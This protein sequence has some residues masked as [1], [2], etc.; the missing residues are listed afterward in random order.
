MIL[1]KTS[2]KILSVVF[3]LTLGGFC[4]LSLLLPDRMLSERENRPL[5][6]LPELSVT[7]VFK[8]EYSQEMDQY[9]SDQFPGRD[10]FVGVKSLSERASGKRENN[11]I[12]FL[13]NGALA[14]RFLL[15]DLSLAEGNIE[16]VRRFSEMV[17]SPVTLALIP[18]VA[19]IYP[20][21]LPYGAPQTDQRTLID[22][23]YTRFGGNTADLY[24]ML[25]SHRGEELYFRTDHHWTPLGAYY[26]YC[27]SA[28]AMGLNPGTMGEFSTFSENFYGTL[29]RKAGSYDLSP[30]CISAPLLS[31]IQ[32]QVTEGETSYSAPVY[33]YSSLEKIDQYSLFLGGDHPLAVLSGGVKN[34]KKILIVKDSYANCEASYFLTNFEEVHLVDLRYYRLPLSNYIEQQGIDQVLISYAL[35]SFTADSNL[36][37]LR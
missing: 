28:E 1:S 22:T 13:K 32:L 24:G 11:G 34:G 9:L 37:F 8:G 6:Q 30:D 26:G 21:E 12:Y 36:A 33:A 31:D 27:A 17:P 23:L 18:S 19:G 7:A 10:F 2:A 4:L 29:W 35:P 16:A 15:T 20:D 25:Y 3:C 14:E 5:Q